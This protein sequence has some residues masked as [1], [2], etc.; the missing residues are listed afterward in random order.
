[1]PSV[2]GIK[3]S[4]GVIK[5][6]SPISVAKTSQTQAESSAAAIIS[7][8]Q[9]A[10]EASGKIESDAL[11][12]TKLTPYSS[13]SITQELLSGVQRILMDTY[14]RSSVLT[15]YANSALDS[16][17]KSALY[18]ISKDSLS[19]KRYLLSPS[20]L[21]KTTEGKISALIHSAASNFL[22]SKLASQNYEASK[23]YTASDIGTS[24]NSNEELLTLTT[25]KARDVIKKE[26]TLSSRGL[27]VYDLKTLSGFA[28]YLSDND[29][30]KQ[31]L[32]KPPSDINSLD[33]KF[34]VFI[35]QIAK[36]TVSEINSRRGEVISI[37]VSKFDKIDKD[38][39]M[40]LL[41]TTLN[42]DIDAFKKSIE[43]NRPSDFTVKEAE[44]S[45]SLVRNVIDSGFECVKDTSQK[46]L[47]DVLSDDYAGMVKLRNLISSTFTKQQATASIPSATQIDSKLIT[48]S[49]W[50]SVTA[51]VVKTYG[52]GRDGFG[53][54]ANKLLEVTAEE[55][56]QNL[57]F[58]K[59]VIE[60]LKNDRVTFNSISANWGVKDA[61]IFWDIAHGI[62]QS[63]ISGSYIAPTISSI[64]NSN[65]TSKSLTPTVA[66]VKTPTIVP[67][68]LKALLSAVSKSSLLKL[69]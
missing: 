15:S 59:P 65:L 7:I 31:I 21:L 64:S 42:E 13:D 50:L 2:L 38:S 60:A 24:N 9:A 29:K 4:L 43:K 61:G 23:S 12:L 47:G 18:S 17:V 34:S 40:K 11:T 19:I 66:A 20:N 49:L 22:E 35:R 58:A 52:T 3:N 55:S 53:D 41:S 30:L 37:D 46:E 33:F 27:S 32:E 57:G 51:E 45:Y 44:T 39:F 56:S 28:T 67:S 1:M 14:T 10:Q 5:T 48:D 68:T 63:Q 16:S 8:S 26:M 25:N 36:S 6:I 62:A 69:K 54:G